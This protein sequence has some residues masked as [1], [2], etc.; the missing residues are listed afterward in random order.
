VFRRIANSAVAWS[1]VFNCLRLASGLIVLPIV[2]RKFSAADFGMY[3]VLLSLARV[4]P[5]IDF[6]FAPTIARFVSYAYG[7]VE[8]LSAHGIEKPADMAGPNYALLWQL[9]RATR[10]LYRYLTLAIL[11]ILGTWGTYIIE[12]RVHETSS[13]LITRLAWGATLAA[14]AADIYLSWWN[15][16]LNGMNQVVFAARIGALAMVVR[17]VLSVALLLIG[18]GL[19][20]LPVAGIVSSLLDRQLARSRCRKLLLNGSSIK[21]QPFRG[22][23]RILWPNSWRLGVQFLSGYLII[24]ANIQICEHIFGL[25]ATGKY[26][27]ATQLLGIAATMAAVWTQTK[28]P[29]IAQHQARH[30][31]A[32]LRK[33]FRPRVWLQTLTFLALAGA[34]VFAG[35]PLLKCYGHGKEML[36]F[37]WMLLLALSTFLEMNFSLWT[38]LIVTQNR[39]P[40]LWPTAVTNVLSLLLT[41]ALIH[42]TTLGLGALVSAPLLAG[43]LFNYWYWPFEAT[44]NLG[45]TLRRFL[46][47]GPSR[48]AVRNYGGVG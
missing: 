31:F 35:P 23:L 27:L 24:N 8:S 40:F 30:E 3:G 41:L 7:G 17:L 10:T 33:I 46:F 14:A 37:A 12:L 48:T 26:A 25:V 44:R 42:F 16:F 13:L 29:I 34:V 36:P 38:T 4:V 1:G 9:L 22:M 6:G 18:A 39:L 43:S 47:P 5:I 21:S 19:L 45:T 11:L 28:W 32:Q 2:L 15:T 20:S